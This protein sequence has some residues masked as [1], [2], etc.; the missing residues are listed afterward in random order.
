MESRSPNDRYLY[1]TVYSF[2]SLPVR[3]KKKKEKK[4]KKTS[5]NNVVM[6]CT[7]EEN[8]GSFILFLFKSNIDINANG[9]IVYVWTEH[10]HFSY[11]Y[12]QNKSVWMLKATHR[13]LIDGLNL[14]LL[15]MC[16]C[17]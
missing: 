1:M 5:L 9:C 15:Y 10:F 2:S 13:E 7:L 11:F 16:F 8:N 14:N 4:G 3:Q 12:W 17:I 6:V